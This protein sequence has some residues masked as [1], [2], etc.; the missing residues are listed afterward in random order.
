M[1]ALINLVEQTRKENPNITS[2]ELANL[3]RE[4]LQILILKSIYQSKFGQS[5]SFV[6]G[7]CLRIC[8][9]LKR[10][11][12]DLDFSLDKKAADYDF[13]RLCQLVQR[14]LSLINI[15]ADLNV[16]QE[17]TVQ[18][19]FVKVVEVIERL[20]LSRIKGQKIHI[21][22]E[23]DTNPVD[24]KFGKIESFFVSKYNEIFPILKHDLETLFAGKILAILGR[25][26]RRGRDF[27]DL[28]WYLNR[29]VKIN[30]TYLNE[31]LKQ[32]GYSS[33]F[34]GEEEVLRELDEIV[35]GLE[36]DFIL[37]D[38]GRFLEDP[39]EEVWLKRYREIYFQLRK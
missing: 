16:S 21:K 11:S 9:D 36:P 38:I 25:P 5:L 34:A 12:E 20:G 27:Y 8:Y 37:D 39:S 29:K 19:A 15:G 26:Y 1:Q 35:N 3:V 13:K 14:D 23:V 22:L 30:L 17:K 7:T 18:K 32:A 10:Y 28:I 2:E 4:Y 31:G 6:G 33:E 24:I